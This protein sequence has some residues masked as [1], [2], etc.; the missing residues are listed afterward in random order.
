MVSD[1][2]ISQYLI[3]K[4]DDLPPQPAQIK[5]ADVQAIQHDDSTG[6]VIETL[7]ERGHSGFTWGEVVTYP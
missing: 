6:G 2:S 7:K 3:D 4:S 1:L 5:C